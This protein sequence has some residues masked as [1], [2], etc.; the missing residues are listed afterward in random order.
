MA[1]WHE[2]TTNNPDTMKA[3]AEGKGAEL[4][5]TARTLGRLPRWE[6]LLM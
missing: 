4:Q 3:A 2:V 6:R 1:N 5:Q